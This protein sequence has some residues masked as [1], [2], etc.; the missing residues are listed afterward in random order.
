MGPK[1]DA[2]AT[3]VR[4]RWMEAMLDPYTKRPFGSIAT[5]T[6]V[7]ELL[8][9][10]EQREQGKAMTRGPRVRYWV[11]DNII[12]GTTNRLGRSSTSAGRRQPRRVQAFLD[13]A[14]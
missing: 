5:T 14:T 13:A 2:A 6:R 8:I 3:R 1:G 11:D 9:R 7:G 4:P 10:L 12:S